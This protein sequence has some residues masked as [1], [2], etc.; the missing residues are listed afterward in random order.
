[1]KV[2]A[3]IL[4][5]ALFMQRNSPFHKSLTSIFLWLI[6]RI[7]LTLNPYFALLAVEFAL[8]LNTLIYSPLRTKAEQ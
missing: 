5:R 1:M 3:D 8:L 4:S 7:P 2:Y 6:T